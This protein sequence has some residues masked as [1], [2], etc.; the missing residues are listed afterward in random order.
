[1][2]G[3]STGGISGYNSSNAKI[4]NSYNTGIVDSGTESFVGGIAGVNNSSIIENVYN[5][6][7]IKSPTVDIT[8]KGQIVGTSNGELI[9]LYWYKAGTSATNVYGRIDGGTVTNTVEITS[10]ENLKKIISYPMFDF[11]NIWYINQDYTYPQL[12]NIK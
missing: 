7:I 12:R 2:D 11:T 6:G 8:C 1:M 5:I 10:E 3:N 9:N 4:K